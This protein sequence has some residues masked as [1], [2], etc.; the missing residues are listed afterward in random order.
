MKLDIYKTSEEW[1]SI[2]YPNNE[3]EI[4]EPNGWD[5]NDFRT[6]YYQE[7]ISEQEFNLRILLSEIKHGKRK[8]K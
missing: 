8:K 3:I 4:L 2:L 6:S 1:F 7:R 5:K